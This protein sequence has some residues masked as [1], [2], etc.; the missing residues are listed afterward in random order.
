[1]AK[2]RIDLSRVV[3]RGEKRLLLPITTAA[4]TAAAAAALPFFL[5][6]FV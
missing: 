3:E 2:T 5:L 6:P 4:A 1:M